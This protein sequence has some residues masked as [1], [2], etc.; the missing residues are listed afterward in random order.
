MLAFL[1]LSELPQSTSSSA[2]GPKRPPKWMGSKHRDAFVFWRRCEGSLRGP[3]RHLFK[4]PEQLIGKF[5]PHYSRDIRSPVAPPQKDMGTKRSS[6]PKGVPPAAGKGK[7]LGGLSAPHFY[8]LL[9][10]AVRK[11]AKLWLRAF[12]SPQ[13]TPFSLVEF[14]NAHLVPAP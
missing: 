3:K 14:L 7:L 5:Y 13:R 10:V 11:E 1:A 9:N 2:C 8:T 4:T 12:P 6:S